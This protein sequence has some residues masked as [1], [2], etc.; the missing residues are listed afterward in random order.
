MGS[1]TAGACLLKCP[2][3][4]CNSRHQRSNPEVV[5][6]EWKVNQKKMNCCPTEIINDGGQQ[7]ETDET[8][9]ACCQD[10]QGQS[11]AVSRKTVLL[12]LKPHLL[13]QAMTGTY[14]FCKGPDCPVVY[15]QEQGTQ[16]FT[17]DDLR[18][19]VGVKA[20]VDPIP[21]CYCFGFDE[22][23]IRD[24]ISR[25]SRSTILDRISK[26]IREGLCACETRN[27]AGVCCL[28]E[29]N[30]TMKRLQRHATLINE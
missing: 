4:L 18:V 27:P 16:R 26:L 17:T 3:H 5:T 10:C 14:S 1:R 22:S 9:S 11:R 6:G 29:V 25:T 28:G 19:T 7:A 2:G 20:R 30:R 23:H 24:E 8:S 21:L 13:E 15:F 12:M